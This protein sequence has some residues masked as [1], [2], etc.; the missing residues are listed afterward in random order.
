[1]GGLKFKVTEIFKFGFDLAYVNSTAGMSQFRFTKAE[2]WAAPKPMQNYDMS[3][4]HTYSDLDTTRLESDLWAKV[5]IFK[6]AFLYGDWRY[7]DY[8]DDA[9]Y[10]YD[11]SGKISWYTLSLGWSF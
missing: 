10:L 2:D 8:T 1:M 5:T 3:K 7:V 11:T 9:P 4:V 6:S